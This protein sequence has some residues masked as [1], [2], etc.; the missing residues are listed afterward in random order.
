MQRGHRNYKLLIDFLITTFPRINAF[1]NLTYKLINLKHY[2]DVTL[3]SLCRD[4]R[5]SDSV[6]L[7]K[8]QCILKSSD[9]SMTPCRK[10]EVKD[11]ITNLFARF[12]TTD[13]MFDSN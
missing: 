3:S 2:A 4:V 10:N 11:V 12:L 6:D 5:Q 9:V 8:L 1:I 7:E 13:L